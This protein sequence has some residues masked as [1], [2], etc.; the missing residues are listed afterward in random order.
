MSKH[1]SISVGSHDVCA[2]WIE[3]GELRWHA[4]A[5]L[6]DRGGLNAA[7]HTLRSAAPRALGRARVTI[8]LSPRWVDTKQLHG[9]PAVGSARLA[10][11]LLRENERSFF[12]WHD[13][14]ATIVAQFGRDGA[15]WG[16]AFDTEFLDGLAHAVQATRLRVVDIAPAVSALAAA[17]PNRRLAWSCGEHAF[18]IQGSRDG[19]I[20]LQR[21]I[22]DDNVE[23][24]SVPDLLRSLGA[25]AARFLPA[26]AAAVVRR[27]L[28]LGWRPGAD[29]V[30][31]RRQNH[32]V[33]AA[34][35]IALI[36]AGAAAALAPGL[37]AV[38]LTKASERELQRLS[39]T[40]RELASTQSE[41]RRVSDALDGAARFTADRGAVTRMLAAFSEAAPESTAILDIRVDSVEGSFTAIAPRVAE[42]LPALATA[43]G[44][45][46][47]Q[48]TGAVA[49]QTIVGARLERAS[50][51]FHR[52]LARREPAR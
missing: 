14:P 33:N 41:L 27:R 7:L 21:Q 8:V 30:R 45:V 15:A 48:I 42:L 49:R 47:P 44:I 35:C 1:I 28:P 36:T 20:H 17:F 5:P 10:T 31:L 32:I 26:Y 25:D 40:Q 38:L 22:A 4:R 16:A 13:R 6:A 50:F 19:L 37:R 46:A 2:L 29:P 34:A 9:L 24:P 12:L 18:A 43:D 3:S 52:A 51:R 39:V 11:E 23:S